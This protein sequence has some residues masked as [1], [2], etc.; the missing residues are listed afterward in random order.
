MRVTR[1]DVTIPSPIWGISIQCWRTDILFCKRRIR[2]NYH[3]IQHSSCHLPT[4]KRRPDKVSYKAVASRL[5]RH[6]FDK[7]PD[8]GS[9]DEVVH[10]DDT[11]QD[12]TFPQPKREI[13]SS[14][15]LESLA[16]GKAVAFVLYSNLLSLMRPFDRYR[17]DL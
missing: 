1:N 13:P 6:T 7:H 2:H 10:Q 8:P 12:T 11:L 16:A 15:V 17:K 9:Q 14:F 5:S 3:K 4:Y